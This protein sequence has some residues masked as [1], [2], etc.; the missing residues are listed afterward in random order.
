ML[1]ILLWLWAYCYGGLFIEVEFGLLV[2][3]LCSLSCLCKEVEDQINS[4]LIFNDAEQL[5][6]RELR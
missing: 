1:K 5:L 4:A 2:Q 3:D 6:E